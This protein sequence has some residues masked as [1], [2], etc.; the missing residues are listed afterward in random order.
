MFWGVQLRQEIPIWLWIKTTGTIFRAGAPPI[1]VYFSGWIGMFTGGTIWILTHGLLFS[2]PS[3]TQG[4]RI[5][6]FKKERCLKRMEK[7]S[8]PREMVRWSPSPFQNPRKSTAM[9]IGEWFAS[10]LFDLVPIFGVPI[11]GVPCFFEYHFFGAPRHAA[12]RGAAVATWT[13]LEALLSFS[14]A[15]IEDYRDARLGSGVVGLGFWVRPV[16]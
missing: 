9:G 13:R 16:A 5:R 10:S 8:T 15:Q 6:L 3:K 2:K 1:L 4:K 7:E 12:E 14:Q 11:F